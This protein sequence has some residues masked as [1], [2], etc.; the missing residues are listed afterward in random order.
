MEQF[1]PGDVFHID[2][3]SVNGQAVF[4]WVSHYLSPPFDVIQEEGIFRSA[5]VAFNSPEAHALE[6]LAVDVLKAFGMQNSASHTE[7]IRCPDDG[8]YY[9]LETSSRVGGDYLAEMV[10][11]SSGVNLWKEWARLE[12]AAAKGEVYPIP[13]TKRAFSG[14]VLSLSKHEKPENFLF[15]APEVVWQPAEPFRVGCIVA[16]QSREQVM[17]LLDQY[18][19]HIRR[20]Q[21]NAAALP[22]DRIS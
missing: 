15:D 1:K 6:T 17:L 16:S 14:I 8:H 10:E 21:Q 12:T 22:V 3:L 5:T 18:A 11:A 9:F 7:A 2:A 20:D 13:R 19:D 4:T